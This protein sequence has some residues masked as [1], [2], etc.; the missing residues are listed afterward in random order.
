MPHEIQVDHCVQQQDLL[1]FLLDGKEVHVEIILKGQDGGMATPG[2]CCHVADH[3]PLGVDYLVGY[4]FCAG[5]DP[6]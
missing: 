1:L 5:E 4:C 2:T 3:N 6:G